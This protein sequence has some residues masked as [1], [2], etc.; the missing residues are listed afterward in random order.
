MKKNLFLCICV[1]MSFFAFSNHDIPKT[2]RPSFLKDTIDPENRAANREA[3]KAMLFSAIVPGLGQA[4]NHK[5]WK[6]PLFYAAAGGLGYLAIQNNKEYKKYSTALT[7]EYDDDPG[8][9]NVY[10]GIYTTDGLVILKRQ[11]K[12][13]RD[14][15]LIGVGAVYL[16]N[17]IDANVDAHMRKFDE[18]INEKLSLSV[19]PTANVLTT[20]DK[21]VYYSGIKLKLHF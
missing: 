12:R 17:I 16:F 6:I 8:T 11:Y 7:N 13:R 15:S 10:D 9:V 21:P 20:F 3:R 5:Y 4:Y 2:G 18:K 14:L 1:L 19:R